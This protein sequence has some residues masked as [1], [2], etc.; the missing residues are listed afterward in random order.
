MRIIEYVVNRLSQE[1]SAKGREKLGCNAKAMADF[2]TLCGLASGVMLAASAGITG[3][4]TGELSLG[5]RKL[6]FLGGAL[7]FAATPDMHTLSQNI[8]KMAFSDTTWRLDNIVKPLF[9]NTFFAG[10]WLSGSVEPCFK[11]VVVLT[12]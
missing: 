6:C 8:S 11:K 5:V 1:P 10:K 2:F 7:L 9:E 3:D 4:V 12:S